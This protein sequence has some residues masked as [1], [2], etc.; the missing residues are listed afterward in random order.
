MA[1]SVS[2]M[3]VSLMCLGLLTEVFGSIRFNF[4]QLNYWLLHEE[5]LPILFYW[6]VIN[7]SSLNSTSTIDRGSESSRYCWVDC[8]LNL[9]ESYCRYNEERDLDKVDLTGQSAIPGFK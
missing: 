7:C 1:L 9:C 4:Q 3:D 8:H 5:L 6:R 2:F